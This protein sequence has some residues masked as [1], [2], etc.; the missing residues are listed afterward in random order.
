MAQIELRDGTILGEFTKPYIVAEVNTSHGGN[1]D[2][3][4]KMIEKVKEIG[5]SCV[6]FQS[7]S[8]ETLYS[9]TYYD[10]NP[11]AKRIVDKFAFTEEELKEVAEYCKKCGIAFA[12][13]PYSKREVDFLIEEC[14]APYIK[15][16][17]MDCTNYPF[18]EYIAKTGAPIVLSTGMCDMQE[19]KKAVSTIEK[20]GNKKICILHCIANYPAEMSTIRLQNI[21]GLRE[22]FPEYPIGYSDHS[23]GT[24]IAAA[25]VGLGSAMIEKHF[26]LDNSKIGMDNQMAT[27][28]EEMARLVQQCENVQLALGSKERIVLDDELKQRSKMRRSIIV[29]KDHKAGEELKEENLDSKRPGTGIPPEQMKSLIGKKTV[30]DIEKDTLILEQDFQ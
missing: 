22:L 3:A 6:K 7:W 2:E 18:L 9:K 28:P 14:D 25:A 30:K 20:I 21:L 12:S 23:L 4:K 26:T 1:V 10:A 5:C 19:I 24:E 27:E 8:T 29:T 15:V 16:A 13:T 17:S 11:I